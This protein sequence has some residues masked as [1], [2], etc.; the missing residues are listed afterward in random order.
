M[1]VRPPIPVLMRGLWDLALAGTPADRRSLQGAVEACYGRTFYDIFV[2]RRIERVL[3]VPCEQVHVDVG[4]LFWLIPP[5]EQ[6]S[7]AVV[8]GKILRRLRDAFR[9]RVHAGASK[10]FEAFYPSPKGFGGFCESLAQ[11]VTT[12]GGTISTN[13]SIDS[14]R[15]AQ[16]RVTGMV[17]NG[18]LEEVDDVVWTGELNPL[19]KLLGLT[20]EPA[21]PSVNLALF[22]FEM[23]GSPTHEYLW[24]EYAEP[25]PLVARA[26]VTTLH[27]PANAP[28]GHYGIS[29]EV[30]CRADEK[31]WEDPA[32]A[33]AAVQEVLVRTGFVPD[34]TSFGPCHIERFPRV[35]PLLDVGYQER[36][37]RSLAHLAQAAGN[38]HLTNPA[39]GGFQPIGCII[40]RALEVSR[41]LAQAP[42][43]PP[44]LVG[45]ELS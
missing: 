19:L 38:V 27:R 5:K 34:R 25:D 39:G 28:A 42:A 15:V 40:Q 12:G 1:V 14:L 21:P 43:P 16:G 22:N 9:P 29:A 11:A 17:I 44:E 3:G 4:T 32:S 2:R 13:A 37:H 24:V 7:R 6:L 36:L 33:V 26:S 18:E 31:L 8:A 23:A 41:R 45:S 30:P 20:T 10:P 35:W